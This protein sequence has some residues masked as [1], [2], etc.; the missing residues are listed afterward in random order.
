MVDAINAIRPLH[1]APE[2]YIFLNRY[3]RPIDQKNFQQRV[4]NRALRALPHIKPRDMYCTRDTFI[5]VM[6]D[7]GYTAKEIADVCGNSPTMIFAH[8][9]GRI[10]RQGEVFGARALQGM[11]KVVQLKRNR[12]RRGTRAAPAK[13]ETVSLISRK[14]AKIA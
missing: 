4:F 12:T 3:G 13:S 10:Q 2:N 14:S 11:K 7:Y 6:L 9:A 8:Y 1:H 5:T